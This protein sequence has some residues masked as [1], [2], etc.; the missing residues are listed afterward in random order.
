VPIA[1]N[2]TWTALPGG[3]LGTGG[4][5][6]TTR[7]TGSTVFYPGAL[8]NSL[9][10]KDLQP[11]SP[12]IVLKFNS[13]ATFHLGT[14]GKPG[15][16]SDFVSTVLHEIGHGL[17]FVGSF[18]SVAGKGT[19]GGGK[20]Y[21][22][23]CDVMIEDGSGRKLVEYP[24]NSTALDDAMTSNK[25]VFAGPAAIKANGGTAPRLYAP[26]GTMAVRS[27]TGTRRRSHRATRTR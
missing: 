20:N 1:I 21:P 3:A 23:I 16:R 14:D 4:A 13:A 15:T 17:G 27:S 26:S 5:A 25:V 2:A 19:F 7:P 10:G 24:N 11:S 8:A 6:W 9:A 22:Y 12:E 18:D